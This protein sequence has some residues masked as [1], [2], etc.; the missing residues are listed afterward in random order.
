MRQECPD[1]LQY[2]PPP[3][4]NDL[5]AGRVLPF[6]GAGFSKNAITPPGVT[7]PD[8]DQLARSLATQ[9][10]GYIYMG[11][12]DATFAYEQAYGRVKLI[13]E[14][15]AQLNREDV[16]PGPA[17]V[18]FAELPF[19]MV[20]TTNL[21]SLL[22]LAYESEGRAVY[23][24]MYEGQLSYFPEVSPG[25]VTL[26]KPHGGFN[27][28]DR[29]IVTERDYDTFATRFPLYSIY[30]ANLFITKTPLFIGYSMNDYDFRF[31]YE[32]VSR[33]LGPNMRLGYTIQVDDTPDD[34]TR[35]ER[36][37]VK[38]INLPSNGLSFGRVLT[39]AF[40]QL[41]AYWLSHMVQAAVITDEEAKAALREPS[42]A[43]R[44]PCLCA[45]PERL[46][47]AYRKRVFP[48]LEGHG[49]IPV[50]GEE[51][52]GTGGQKTAPLMASAGEAAAVIADQGHPYSAA[53]VVR[54]SNIPVLFVAEDG[55]RPVHVARGVR[56]VTRAAG[57]ALD[58][59]VPEAIEQ[60]LSELAA[61]P[62]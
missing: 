56:V 28:P 26:L 14:M 5:V 43:E 3:F 20:A 19:D 57:D 51:I 25:S 48:L 62:V 37:G 27:N 2:F 50:T 11:T 54:P 23:P 53:L 39:C 40:E 44:R 15:A 13:E 46:V 35:F 8:F 32:S 59:S 1:Y 24:V 42:R 33:Q 17:H 60:W 61:W 29:I 16:R 34:I 45:V 41:R 49:F 31:T 30:L 10:P 58:P 47:A 6:I 18:A 21:D 4:L 36:R 52:R 38:V 12:T 9:I 7:V 55:G 22:E